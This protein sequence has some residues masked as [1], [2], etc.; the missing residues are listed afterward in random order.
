MEIKIGRKVTGDNVI[1]IP[2]SFKKASRVHATVVYNN[3]MMKIVDEDSTHG[4]YIKG[5]SNRFAEKELR[6]GNVL[7]LG[8]YDENDPMVF[9]IS[10]D[11]IKKK[12][13]EIACANKTDYS[14]EFLPLKKVYED[15]DTEVKNLKEKARKKAAQQRIA[16]MSVGVLISVVG[17]L[18]GVTY[19]GSAV[20]VAGLVAGVIIK[21]AELKE[22]IIEINLKYKHDYRCPNPKCD[23]EYNLD[24]NTHH[25]K[26]LEDGGCPYCKAKFK[27]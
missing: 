14:N 7:L 5:D 3:G 21:P 25:W 2:E 16:I 1:L 15:Y 17:V 9:V 23:K 26:I 24:S 4:T 19:L 13:D 22:E 6:K 10:Y 12:F 11:E 8:G 27:K 18:T 20:V